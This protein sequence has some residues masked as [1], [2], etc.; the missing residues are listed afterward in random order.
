MLT[1]V[2]VEQL[3]LTEASYTI[4]RIAQELEGIESRDPQPWTESIGVVCTIAN[5]VKVS[6]VP[7]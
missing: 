3:A 2:F 7:C 5:G 1:G 6:V 4:I